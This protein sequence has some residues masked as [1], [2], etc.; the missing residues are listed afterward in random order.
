[1][2]TGFSLLD[3]KFPHFLINSTEYLAGRHKSSACLYSERWDSRNQCKTTIL[4]RK[5]LKRMIEQKKYGT[6]FVI[7]GI[8]Q[9]CEFSY[10]AYCQYFKNMALFLVMQDLY[11]QN[12]LYFNE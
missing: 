7:L 9:L 12:T 5:T 10:H 1:M 6:G 4:D 3:N 8:N 2:L 11:N